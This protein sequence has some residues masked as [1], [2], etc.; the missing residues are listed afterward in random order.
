MASSLPLSPPRIISLTKPPITSSS[1]RRPRSCSP[2]FWRS[3]L[4][5]CSP[6]TSPCAAVATS[7]SRAISRNPSPWSSRV[8]F[9]YYRDMRRHFF[10]ALHG[11]LALFLLTTGFRASAQ[12]P[13][14]AA[15]AL[16]EI[17]A[18]GEKLLTE[19]QVIAITGLT[20]AAQIGKNDLQAAADKLV[21]S[22]LF[23]K[24]NYTFQTKVT[25]VFVT[26]HVEEAPR[27][28]VYFDNIPWL[29]DSTMADAIRAKFPFFDGSL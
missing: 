15:A 6:I 4:F 11:A 7:T 3:F 19:A 25:G 10:R 28:P 9:R 20:P 12:T 29:A 27:I 17:H 26:Y 18:G 5:N 21:Q 14:A 2:L 23:A 1:F 16:R 8:R 24:V 22:G 13:D